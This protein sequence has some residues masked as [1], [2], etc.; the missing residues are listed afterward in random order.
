MNRYIF[1]ELSDMHLAYGD[2]RG[3]GRESRRIYQERYPRQLPHH[4]TFTSIDRRLRDGSLEINRSTAVRPKTVRTSALE[5]AVLDAIEE[6]PSSSTRT[7]ARD[8]SPLT[9]TFCCVSYRT[10][11][12]KGSVSGRMCILTFFLILLF[13]TP[14][15]IL[16]VQF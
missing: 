15:S 8:L 3:N 13:R 4:T 11:T 7:T 1:A 14:H 9:L 2:A 10:V 12:H 16:S 5:E 6:K